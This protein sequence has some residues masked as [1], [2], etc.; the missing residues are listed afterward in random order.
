[1]FKQHVVKFKKYILYLVGVENMATDNIKL[2]W[3]I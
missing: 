2:V 1:M 3:L